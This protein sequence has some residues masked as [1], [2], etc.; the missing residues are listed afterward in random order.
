MLCGWGR[1][2]LCRALISPNCFLITQG[3]VVFQIWESGTLDIIISR[4]ALL[5]LSQHQEHVSIS[6]LS[7]SCFPTFLRF[8]SFRYLSKSQ[9][10]KTPSRFLPLCICSESLCLEQPSCPMQAQDPPSGWSTATWVS[11][12]PCE[13]QNSLLV[14]ASSDS[15]L[16]LPSLAHL[17]QTQFI[18]V[19]A[20][21][22]CEQK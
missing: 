22:G 11:W 19:G 1:S 2:H 15:C 17:A 12:S 13:S 18:F 7:A 21:P 4:Q 3:M 14:G 6:G 10:P 16:H 5:C 9:P 20:K 8:H